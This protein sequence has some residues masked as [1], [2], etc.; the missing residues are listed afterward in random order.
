MVISTSTSTPLGS[1]ALVLESSET[2][3]AIRYAGKVYENA[4]AEWTLG[5]DNRESE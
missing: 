1:D 2:V 4:R 3:K 5:Y